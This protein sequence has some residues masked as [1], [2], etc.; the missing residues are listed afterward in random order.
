MK[1]TGDYEDRSCI[2]RYNDA[3]GDQHHEDVRS[4]L[5]RGDL[6]PSVAEVSVSE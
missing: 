6:P 4:L 1:G 3:D 2:A 5:Y